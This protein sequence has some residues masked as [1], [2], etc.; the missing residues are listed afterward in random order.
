MTRE[1]LVPHVRVDTDADELWSYGYGMWFIM[2]KD[3]QIIRY[4]H[5]GDD[6]GINAT[7]YYYPAHDIDVIILGNQSE[8]AEPLNWE[9][10]DII[11]HSE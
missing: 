2:N 3:S 11:L 1:M 6:P 4:G 9:I 5:S 8:C 10:Q 7:V